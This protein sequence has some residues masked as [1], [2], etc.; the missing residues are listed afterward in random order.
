MNP[1]L[2]HMSGLH[3]LTDDVIAMDIL[4]NAKS[5]VRNYAMAVTESATPEIKQI[6][7]KQLDEAIDSHEKISNYMMQNGLYH[8][9]HIS[10]QIQLDLKNIQTAMDIQS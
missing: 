9:Y 8:P 10:E 1:I 5:A 2:E 7:M 4:I 3:T 6:L